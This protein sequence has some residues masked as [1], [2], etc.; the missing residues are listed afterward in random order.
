M[1]MWNADPRKPVMN[2]LSNSFI[3]YDTESSRIAR[4]VEKRAHDLIEESDKDETR[5]VRRRLATW[6]RREVLDPNDN[7]A[8]NSMSDKLA[9]NRAKLASKVA[10]D[11]IG[12]EDAKR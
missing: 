7:E 11:P 8:M 1:I 12:K 6:G 4:Q 2:P 5:R 9:A 3:N 10:S